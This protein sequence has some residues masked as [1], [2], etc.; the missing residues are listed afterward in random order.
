LY[1]SFQTSCGVDQPQGY[2]NQEPLERK[3]DK[4]VNETFARPPEPSTKDKQPTIP[5]IP[6]RN[7]TEPLKSENDSFKAIHV[8]II[9]ESNL[10]DSNKQNLTEN[11]TRMKRSVGKGRVVRQTNEAIGSSEEITMNEQS[12]EIASKGNLD[13]HTTDT[14]SPGYQ[15]N[16]RFSSKTST[17]YQNDLVMG[18]GDVTSGKPIAV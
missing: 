15:R 14:L 5:L 13:L 10:L 12:E 4:E 2:D 7:N 9:A 3:P 11:G 18:N 1:H 6:E 16:L 17:C 8:D